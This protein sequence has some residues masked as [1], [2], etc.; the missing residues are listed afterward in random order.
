MKQ[1]PLPADKQLPNYEITVSPDSDKIGQNIGSLHFWQATGATIIAI[2]R[3]QN[4][5]ISPGPFAELYS[6]DV[7]VFVGTPESAA[8]VSRYLNPPPSC[9][10]DTAPAM[11]SSILLLS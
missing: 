8:A 11:N 1:Q 4:T 10:G 3:N 9:T 7:V 2:R 6:G 5:I